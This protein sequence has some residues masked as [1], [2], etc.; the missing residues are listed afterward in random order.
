LVS[1]CITGKKCRYNASSSYNEK[2][3]KDIGEKF[4]HICPELLAG[5]GIPRKPCEIFGGSGEDV[6]SGNAN[7]MDIDG[8]DITEKMLIG[9]K[10]ALEICQKNNVAKAFLQTKSPTC[11]C[12]KIYDGTFTSTIR[13][14]NGIFT[15]LLIMS[16]IDVTEIE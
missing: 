3:L 4:I 1:S 16:G 5:F 9:S 10:K 12:N 8:L 13:R 2:L 14:G 15:A 7:I 11:G 6:L